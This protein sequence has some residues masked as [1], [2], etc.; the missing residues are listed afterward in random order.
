MHEKHTALLAVPPL[1]LAVH[2]DGHQDRL[3]ILL[4]QHHLDTE[5]IHSVLQDTV[6]TANTVFKSRGVL[7][8]SIP[9]T[10]TEFG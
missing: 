2:D 6:V 7:G 8:C 5:L 4:L 3:D 9:N 10:R 1:G